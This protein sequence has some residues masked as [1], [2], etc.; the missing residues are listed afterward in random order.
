MLCAEL[1]TQYQK[2]WFDYKKYSSVLK[3]QSRLAENIVEH[4]RYHPSY[5]RVAFYGKGFPPSLRGKQF[6]YR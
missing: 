5:Y 4:E 2:A 6:V 1:A 3:Y